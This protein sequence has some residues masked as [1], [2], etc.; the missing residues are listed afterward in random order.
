MKKFIELFAASLL[1]ALPSHANAAAWCQG[2]INDILTYDNGDVGIWSTWRTG[3]TT[4]CNVKTE[5]KGIAPEACFVWFSTASASIVENKAT[6][7]YYRTIDQ[8]ECATMPLATS[9]PAPGYLRMS[10]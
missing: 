4:I 5:W 1:L 6:V 3:W 9:A 10:K 2:Y 7:M 8:A